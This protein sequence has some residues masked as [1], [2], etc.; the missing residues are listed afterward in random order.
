MADATNS[1]GPPNSPGTTPPAAKVAALLDD[2]SNY[3]AL[4]ASL[5]DLLARQFTLIAQAVNELDRHL[6]A[7]ERRLEG[8]EGYC[9]KKVG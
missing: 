1:T 7:I 9:R 3:L 6:E 4:T 8:L 2:P 5:G